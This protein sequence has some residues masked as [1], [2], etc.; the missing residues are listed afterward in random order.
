MEHYERALIDRGAR[1][2]GTQSV[3]TTINVY[4]FFEVTVE[5][6]IVC[7]VNC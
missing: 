3:P 5:F 7:I 1:R 6:T 2:D 4:L